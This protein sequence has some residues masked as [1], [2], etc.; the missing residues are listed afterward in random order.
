MY[1][2]KTML[3][4]KPGPCSENSNYR[5]QTHT[6]RRSSVKL[7]PVIPLSGNSSLPLR[8]SLATWTVLERSLDRSGPQWEI[9]KPCRRTLY[10][11]TRKK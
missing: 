7:L 9:R 1:M 4:I 8:L 10:P 6:H 3:K 11:T 2:H 5:I